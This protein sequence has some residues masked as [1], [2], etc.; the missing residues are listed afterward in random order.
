MVASFVGKI[1]A[2]TVLLVALG[3]LIRMAGIVGILIV[4][5]VLIYAWSRV[6]P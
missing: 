3:I 4:I 2:L 5:A 6:K 1:L